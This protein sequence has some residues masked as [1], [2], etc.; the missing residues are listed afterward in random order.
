MLYPL[1]WFLSLLAS[2][3]RLGAGGATAELREGAGLTPVLY[4]FEACPHCRIT[5]EAVSAAGLVVLVKPCPKKG[6]RFRPE[7]IEKGGLAQFPFLYDANAN[8]GRYESRDL[9]RSVLG[10]AGMPRPFVHWLGPLNTALS[11]YATLA[12][13]MAGRSATASREAGLPLVY[14]G[15]ER[16]PGGRLVRER[17]CVLEVPYVWR[18]V[19]GPPALDDPN[20]DTRVVGAR[21]ILAHLDKTYRA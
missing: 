8:Q 3:L 1:H 5:R 12:R 7:V 2:C 13:G 16:S 15:A 11:S 14:S 4:E 18:P 21:A 6:T 19:A 17:L 10:E 20:A 9:A